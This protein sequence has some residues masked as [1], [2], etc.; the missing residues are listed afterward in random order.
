MSAY[1][2]VLTVHLLAAAMLVGNSFLTPVVRNLLCEATTPD[3]L[4]QLLVF[5]RRI[6]H[7]TPMAAGIVLVTGIYLGSFGWW[8]DGWFYVSIA[9]WIES[10]LLAVRVIDRLEA[11][12]MQAAQNLGGSEL[13]E[14]N[15]GRRST[16][17]NRALGVMVANDVSM[18]F[19]M[20]SKP[21]L[22]AALAFVVVANAL[23]VTAFMLTRRRGQPLQ[24]PSVAV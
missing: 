11:R 15:S 5:V 19:L 9:L 3:R 1:T 23:S 13:V 6:T 16:R 24:G 20:V 7:S 12:W 17:W 18:V 22:V 21:G 10:S 2:L 4:L 8:T 14:L